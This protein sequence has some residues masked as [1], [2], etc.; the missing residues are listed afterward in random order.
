[1]R[2]TTQ[3]WMRGNGMTS[4]ERFIV[5]QPATLAAPAAYRGAVFFALAMVGGCGGGG[6]NSS[7]PPPPP[8][9]TAS[10]GGIWVGT[11]PFSTTPVLGLVAETGELFFNSTGAINGGVYYVGQFIVDAENGANANIDAIAMPGSEYPDGATFAMGTLGGK[12][13]ERTSIDGGV[14]VNTYP[15]PPTEGHSY[16][17]ALSLTFSSQYNRPS[18]LATIAGNFGPSSLALTI[19]SDGALFAQDGNTGCVINGVITTIDTRFNM[20]A[21]TLSTMNC[22]TEF[23]VPDGAQLKGL[24]TLNNSQSPEYVIIRAADTV[25]ATKSAMEI[26]MNRM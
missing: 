26:A 18:S 11:D 20:Y 14:N 17:Y 21:V 5:R 7:P 9:V 3:P 16:S 22:A 15:P 1:M 10:P 25:S 24:A 6:G 4:A 23:G 19:S 12:L 13:V 2:S 8:P